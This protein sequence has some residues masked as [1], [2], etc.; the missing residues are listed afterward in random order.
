MKEICETYH[1][2]A[3][4]ESQGI[5]TVS[6]DEKTGIQALERE[7]PTK[8]MIPGSVEKREYNY[9]RH[10]TTCLFG[11][12]NIATG[13][14][15][16]P[17]LNAT[18]NEADFATN[19]ENIIAT[20]P[21]KGWVFVLDNLNTHMSET[22]V[23]LIAERLGITDDLGVK[24]KN[25]ILKSMPS[26]K[27]FLSDKSHRIRFVYTPKHCSWLNQIENWFSGL[28]RRVLNRGSF[29]SVDEL[30]ANIRHYINFYNQ[31]A[32]PMKWKFRPE[33]KKNTPL[34]I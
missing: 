30:Q 14:V 11:N 34:Q 25:G 6:I 22:L 27:A 12:L 23:R 13:E 2:A 28:V 26:R 21:D 5:H 16:A 3:E 9:E 10:G 1:A 18:R 15:I 31:T 17:M 7:A 8:P 32:K 19:I 24:D 33:K 4:N 29:R 20:E